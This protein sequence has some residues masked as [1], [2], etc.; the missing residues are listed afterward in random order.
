MHQT[1]IQ[2]SRFAYANANVTTEYNV[3][4]NKTQD[5]LNLGGKSYR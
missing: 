5:I 3:C 1:I 4:K 2:T